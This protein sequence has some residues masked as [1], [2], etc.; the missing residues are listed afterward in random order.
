MNDPI[1]TKV[2][3]ATDLSSVS[4]SAFEYAVRLSRPWKAEI[5][6]LHV[7]EKVRPSRDNLLEMVASPEMIK[8]IRNGHREQA[9]DVLI[10]KKRNYSQS[11]EPSAGSEWV[12]RVSEKV[13]TGTNTAVQICEVAQSSGCDLIVMGM[14]KRT[15]IETLLGKSTVDRVIEKATLPVLVLPLDD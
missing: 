2:L 1:L 5:V 11:G 6:I 4:Q 8:S 14:H 9:R 12:P 15:G 13:I 10:G 7:L 3:F